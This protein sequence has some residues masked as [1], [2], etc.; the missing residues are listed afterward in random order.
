MDST[1]G[2]RV[3]GQ[4]VQSAILR[5]GDLVQGGSTVLRV[6][7]HA[8]RPANGG[9][10]LRAS[11]DESEPPSE[12]ETTASFCPR[13][14]RQT[15]T[16]A[17]GL[18]QPSEDR[19]EVEDAP[20]LR[21]YEVVRC[22][23]RGGMGIV[24]LVNRTGDGTQH[25]LKM[26]RPAGEVSGRQLRQF[27]REASIL[28]ALVHPNIVTFHEIGL[29]GE[30]LYF[31][32]DY[33]RGQDASHLLRRTGPLPIGFAVRLICQV[34]RALEYAHARGYVHRDVKPSNLLISSEAPVATCL[35]ADFGLARLYHASPISG[36]TLLGDAGG[37]IPYMPPEQI[38]DFRAA[39]PTADQY[40]AAATLYRLITG[41]HLFDFGTAPNH[42]KL[43]KILLDVPV[44]IRSRRP[45]IP[46]ELAQAI[47]R[48]VSHETKQ[49]YPDVKAFR[50]AILPFVNMN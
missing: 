9:T 37:T 16:L 14:Q 38:M 25:A 31:A 4:R 35:L 22:L 39:L 6:T 40:S 7:I 41:H 5:N 3:N 36:L 15:A 8:R 28:Q 47:H 24:Y 12:P 33:V 43:E 45:E 11:E 1:N 50:E 20:K 23:G 42:K 44:D 18:H 48:A 49:R 26:I 46:A 29:D 17:N 21:G 10:F 34:L 13:S 30:L 19:D 32:M 27:L 2:T